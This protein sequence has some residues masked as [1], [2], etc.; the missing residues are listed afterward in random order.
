MNKQ[1]T[2]QEIH[3][4]IKKETGIST[5]IGFITR[6]SMKGYVRFYAKK[7]RGLYPEWGFKYGRDLL[8][9]FKRPE[10]TPTFVN[11]YQLHIYIGVPACWNKDKQAK[12]TFPKAA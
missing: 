7:K 4:K 11:N 9:V 1:T 2:V 5:S 3:D 6:G 8:E 12:I 10:P